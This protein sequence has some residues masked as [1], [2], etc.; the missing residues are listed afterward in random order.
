MRWIS[1]VRHTRRRMWEQGIGSQDHPWGGGSIHTLHRYGTGG[2]GR[3]PAPP[4]C[5]HGRSQALQ[6]GPHCR[7]LVGI[8]A[9]RCCSRVPAIAPVS[10]S[11]QPGVRAAMGVIGK[12]SGNIGRE[13]RPA[14]LL[15]QRGGHQGVGI[16]AAATEVR[17][18]SGMGTRRMSLR[19]RSGSTVAGA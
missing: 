11:L 9:T 8:T 4:S 18:N 13:P 15:G 12:H 14:R 1:A 16:T 3:S 10:A 7:P 19:A 17:D 5:W 6:P 2:G